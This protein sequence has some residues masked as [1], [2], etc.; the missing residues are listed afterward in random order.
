MVLLIRRYR[1]SRVTD[2][3]LDIGGIFRRSMYVESETGVR[4]G[5]ENESNTSRVDIPIHVQTRRSVQRRV[6]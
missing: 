1:V 4:C 5:M 6:R 3:L 2:E